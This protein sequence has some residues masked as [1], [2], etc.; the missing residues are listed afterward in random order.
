MSHIAY[1]LFLLRQLR[2]IQKTKK[3]TPPNNINDSTALLSISPFCGANTKKAG[4]VI[5]GSLF[6]QYLYDLETSDSRTELVICIPQFPTVPFES[7]SL[8]H[9]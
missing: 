8:F 4:Q 5:E 3:T 2:S 7:G 6:D 1:N 9:A